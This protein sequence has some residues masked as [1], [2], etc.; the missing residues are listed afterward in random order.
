MRYKQRHSMEVCTH[1]IRESCKEVACSNMLQSLQTAQMHVSAAEA[2]SICI[3]K[4]CSASW[5]SMEG[6]SRVLSRPLC[7]T[8]LIC[9]E[10]MD[11]ALGLYCA[12]IA[13]VIVL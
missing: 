2:D 13:P 3:L 6:A 9:V 12:C 5:A 7:S 1:P 4:A 10:G 8:N 11:P